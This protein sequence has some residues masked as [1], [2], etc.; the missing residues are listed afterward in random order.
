MKKVVGI[1]TRGSLDIN[2]YFYQ[3]V[4]DDFRTI[5]AELDL[6]A[7]GIMPTAVNNYTFAETGSYKV[8]DLHSV[9]D[10]CDGFII[11]GGDKIYSY[12]MQ[13]IGYAHHLDKPILGICMGMQAMGIFLGGT[14]N[15]IATPNL[16]QS[17][18]SFAHIINIDKTS[19]FYSFINKSEI[20]VNSRHNEAI[21]GLK[22]KY[23]SAK[24][25]DIVEAIEDDNK[26]FFTGVQ[27]HPEDLKDE[28][29]LKLFKR[30]KESI[31]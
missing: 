11:Q 30:F 5:I 26:R 28:N 7:I 22:E 18:N 21:T 14:L 17:S 20:N 24:F 16:H 1:I 3:R 19:Q 12:E 29:T 27:W 6:I 13:T 9:L 10:L 2:G 4:K 25:G 31:D 23:I 15:T 8:S